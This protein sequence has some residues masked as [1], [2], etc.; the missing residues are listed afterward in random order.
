MKKSVITTMMVVSLFS[1]ASA[2]VGINIPD[3]TVPDATLQIDGRPTVNS[4]VDGVL[5][6]RLTV[7]QLAAKDAAYGQAQ[8]GTLVFVTDV[9][10]APGTGKTVDITTKGVYYYDYN[11]TTPANSKWAALTPPEVVAT[12]NMTNMFTGVIP[13]ACTTLGTKCVVTGTWSATDPL[14][15]NVG[16]GGDGYY[17]TADDNIIISL[18]TSNQNYILLPTTGVPVGKIIYISNSGTPNA[19]VRLIGCRD[20]Q[21]WNLEAGSSTLVMYI[22]QTMD[23]TGTLNARGPWINLGKF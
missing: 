4:V 17:A 13:S 1:L 20:N 9:T 19:F 22:G 21:T 5:I 23:S 6:P 18:C 16:T 15:S 10:G 3:N 11:T 2:Q 7:A 12:P 14:D 8:N